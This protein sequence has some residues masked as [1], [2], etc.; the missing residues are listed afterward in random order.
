MDLC[1]LVFTLSRGSTALTANGGYVQYCGW[2]PVYT[3]MTGPGRFVTWC[4][5][6]FW[7]GVLCGWV[8]AKKDLYPNWLEIQQN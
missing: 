4:C 5:R 8:I 3:G 6:P 2:I 1:G 7:V